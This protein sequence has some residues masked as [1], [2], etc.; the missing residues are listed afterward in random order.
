MQY[1]TKQS[2]HLTNDV[3]NTQPQGN[4]KLQEVYTLTGLSRGS[5]YIIV[6]DLI[7]SGSS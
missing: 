6:A 4:D 5:L 7:R 1:L 2:L 3:I